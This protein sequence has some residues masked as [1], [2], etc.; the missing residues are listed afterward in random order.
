MS[1]IVLLSAC[2]VDTIY[3]V[4]G[5]NEQLLKMEY[6]SLTEVFDPEKAVWTLLA[7]GSSKSRACGRLTQWFSPCY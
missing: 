2:V 1:F 4:G 7:D 5:W 3:I 6:Y